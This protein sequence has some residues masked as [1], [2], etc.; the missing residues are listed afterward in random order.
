M[1]D[2]VYAV[3]SPMTQAYHATRSCAGRGGAWPALRMSRG[4][5]VARDL[6]PCG[7]CL[8]ALKEAQI[9]A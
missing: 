2:L 4:A 8:A 5:A 3:P 9:D 7:C 6:G 1:S